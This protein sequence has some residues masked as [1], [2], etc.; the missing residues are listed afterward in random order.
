[1]GNIGK[2][3]GVAKEVAHVDD[4]DIAF[5]GPVEAGAALVIRAAR[6][7]EVH[8]IDAT[9]GNRWQR[10]GNVVGDNL[11]AAGSTRDDRRGPHVVARQEQVEVQHFSA[12]LAFQEANF[13]RLGRAGRVDDRQQGVVCVAGRV[14]AS[15]VVR[16]DQGRAEAVCVQVH[17]VRRVRHAQR[18]QSSQ[19][20]VQ[21]FSFK[22][23]HGF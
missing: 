16:V 18:T 15:R 19:G 9:C 23:V 2:R 10:A 11:G 1:M 21:R 22:R 8:E 20:C 6:V 3:R 14:S 12:V 7:R 13:D 17:R 4:F 5:L